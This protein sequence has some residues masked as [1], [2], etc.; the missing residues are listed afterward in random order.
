M[1]VRDTFQAG[2]QAEMTKAI[3]TVTGR[4]VAAFMSVSHPDPDYSVEIFMLS[5]SVDEAD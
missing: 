1:E 5:E 4:P 2:M 3:E